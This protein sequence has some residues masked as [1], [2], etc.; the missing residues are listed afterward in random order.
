MNF[1]SPSRKL[2][3]GF[4]QKQLSAEL[5][6]LAVSLHFPQAVDCPFSCQ[7]FQLD[8]LAKFQDSVGGK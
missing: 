4:P 6:S 2:T 1:E 5:F 3:P 8:F 7:D